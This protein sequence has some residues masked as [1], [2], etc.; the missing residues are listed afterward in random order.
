MLALL[1]V[2]RWRLLFGGFCVFCWLVGCPWR[3]LPKQWLAVGVLAL[4]ADSG[5][6]C[7][8]YVRQQLLRQCWRNS[9]KLVSAMPCVFM[10]WCPLCPLRML[11]SSVTST[12][13]F[14]TQRPLWMPFCVSPYASAF[15]IE[16]SE[17]IVSRHAII[18]SSHRYSPNNISMH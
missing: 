6:L 5:L 17:A 1:A 2:A 14:A 18:N 12:T 10:F 15:S 4:V 7:G 9:I 8:F 16:H 13:L 11:A 3:R